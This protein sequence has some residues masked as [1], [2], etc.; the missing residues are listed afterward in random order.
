VNKKND[1]DVLTRVATTGDPQ[2]SRTASADGDYP[3]L[4]D[5]FRFQSALDDPPS[6]PWR[7]GR[8]VWATNGHILVA[9]LDDGRDADPTPESKL[10]GRKYLD[11]TPTDLALVSLAALRVFVGVVTPP[12]E[13]DECD[14]TGY[15][16]AAD[17]I[18]CEQCGY[19]TRRECDECGGDGRAGVEPRL[20]RI[21][22]API[23]LELLAYALTYVPADE[24]VQVGTIQSLSPPHTP[25]APALLVIG[26]TWRIAVMSLR[27]PEGN[28]AVFSIERPGEPVTVDAVA[29]PVADQHGPSTREKGLS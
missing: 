28:I 6:R 29:R 27:N 23:N 25:A 10:K 21:A 4:A 19:Y 14:G 24:T 9:F 18:R 3:P 13:C 26:A 12:G 2:S 7:L 5:V 17:S 16:D 11:E 8:W 1:E 22:G 20:G 15:D